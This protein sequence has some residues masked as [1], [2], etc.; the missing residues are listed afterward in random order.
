MT[1]RCVN[2]QDH[3]S[4]KSDEELYLSALTTLANGGAYFFIDA[5][6]PDGTLNEKFY[7]RLKTINERLLPFKKAVAENQ[8]TLDAE[9]GLYF[10]IECCVDKNLD[11]Q[12]LFAFDGG[13]ANNM[14]IRQNA[15]L[16]EA[17]GTAEILNQL[18][19]PFKTVKAGDDLSAY[20]A[21]II[22]NCRYLSPDEC[23]RI[24]HFVAAGGTL[25][26]TGSTSLYDFGGNSNGNFQLAD[27]FGVDFTGKFSDRVNYSGSDL[28]L[29]RNP[30][31][32]V[33][34]GNKT[35]VRGYL[36][37]PDF[38]AGD[39]DNYASIH[40]DPPGEM[41][42]YPAL[43]V[44]RFGKGVCVWLA[45]PVLMHRQHTQQEFGRQLFAEFLPQI[46]TG[47]S[48][49]HPVA[50]FTLLKSKDGRSRMFA[51]VNMPNDLPVIPLYQ[52][53]LELK[54]AGDFQRIIRVSDQREISFEKQGEYT[55]ITIE[56]L[57]YGEFYQLV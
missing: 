43:T 27:V 52:I 42:G 16:D 22:N 54:L 49:L 44:N 23:D 41:T 9:T 11:G 29:A 47:N 13:C 39:A 46:L 8:Y 21:L 35:Q 14:Q 40:S 28:I 48:N 56:K 25:I 10:S 24:R 57:E 4:S 32:F 38:P 2:L 17:L 45:A 51:I 55:V 15:V 33:T 3:T 26:A 7:R 53:R 50:E 18:H 30:A 37:L 34:A 1:S 36:W 19:I 5:I 12:K 20:K 31:P 6:N